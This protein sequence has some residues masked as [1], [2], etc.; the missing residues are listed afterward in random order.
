MVHEAEQDFPL[1]FRDVRSQAELFG[2]VCRTSNLL[3]SSG[4][5]SRA[6]GASCALPAAWL[7]GRVLR[8]AGAQAEARRAARVAA[9]SELP[10]VQRLGSSLG[11]KGWSQHS[12]GRETLLLPLTEP[13]A[14][15]IPAAALQTGSRRKNWEHLCCCVTPAK[16]CCCWRSF[17]GA[18]FSLGLKKKMCYWKSHH[19]FA[20]VTVW[21]WPLQAQSEVVSHHSSEYSC[22][23]KYL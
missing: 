9:C 14:L 5:Q 3:A 7:L 13:R 12:A 16:Q 4:A 23:G 18:W 20:P 6:Q 2:S 17:F 11:R 1:Q 22:A 8:A 15:P 21:Q 10:H 19:N